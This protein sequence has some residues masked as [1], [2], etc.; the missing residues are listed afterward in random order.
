[1]HDTLSALVEKLPLFIDVGVTAICCAGSGVF[2][3]PAFPTRYKL[4]HFLRL[5]LFEL[6]WRPE[7]VHFECVV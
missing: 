4:T 7:Q 3:R 1:M 2:R 5:A 6:S